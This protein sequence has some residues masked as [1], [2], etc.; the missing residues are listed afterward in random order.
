MY[1][2]TLADKNLLS[3]AVRLFG[4]HFDKRICVGIFAA[5]LQP[6]LRWV[7]AWRAENDKFPRLWAH[8]SLHA[9]FESLKQRQQQLYKRK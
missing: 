9:D 5:A 4:Q 6:I 3:V 2:K 8:Y 1:E 7:I